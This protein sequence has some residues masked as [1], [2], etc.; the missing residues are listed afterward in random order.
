MRISVRPAQT[1][2]LGDISRLI[3]IIATL[4]AER[5]VLCLQ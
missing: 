4:V 5:G 2:I 1:L 3:N